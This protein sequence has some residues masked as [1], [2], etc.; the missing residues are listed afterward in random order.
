MTALSEYRTRA[1]AKYPPK[2]IEFDD[3][4]SVT[5]RSPIDMNKAD[6]ALFNQRV[7]ELQSL[8]DTDDTDFEDIREKFVETLADLSDN[9]EVAQAG[10]ADVPLSVLMVIFQDVAASQADASKS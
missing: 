2:P 3:G 10:L 6:S 8:D 1:T 7:K 5:L 4:T 9:P